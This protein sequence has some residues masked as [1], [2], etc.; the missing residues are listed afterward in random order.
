MLLTMSVVFVVLIWIINSAINI[1]A[2]HQ[3]DRN[4][5]PGDFGLGPIIDNYITEFEEFNII[6]GRSIS[7]TRYRFGYKSQYTAHVIIL[8]S[9]STQPDIFSIYPDW[10][11]EDRLIVF[12]R[13]CWCDALEPSDQIF[14][15]LCRNSL[16]WIQANTD[17]SIAIERDYG[18]NQICNPKKHW[19]EFTEY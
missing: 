9:E 13:N 17:I 11:I 16:D 8:E 19:S 4:A 10:L 3:Q 7:P 14:N 5:S 15:D 18:Y 12:S 1:V 2:R 6:V